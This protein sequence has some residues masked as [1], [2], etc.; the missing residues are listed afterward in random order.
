M[1]YLVQG[2]LTSYKHFKVTENSHHLF[3]QIFNSIL[4]KVFLHASPNPF[5]PLRMH[6]EE[7]ISKLLVI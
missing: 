2:W 7:V 5:L 6:T 1:E 3:P 4:P